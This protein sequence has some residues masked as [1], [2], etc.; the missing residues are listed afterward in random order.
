MISRKKKKGVDIIFSE[1]RW[2]ASILKK[3]KFYHQADVLYKPTL[4]EASAF[5][6]QKAF[7]H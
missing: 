4:K 7:D 5:C 2:L 1:D 3:L 6:K